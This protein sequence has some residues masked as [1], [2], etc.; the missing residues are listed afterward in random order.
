MT[1]FRGALSE[2]ITYTYVKGIVSAIPRFVSRRC[3]KFD[4]NYDFIWICVRFLNLIYIFKITNVR[5]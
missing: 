1:L 4:K 3:S 5:M 2:C